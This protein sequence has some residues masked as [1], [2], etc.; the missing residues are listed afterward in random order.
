M[1]DRE[2]RGLYTFHLAGVDNDMLMGS[3][4]CAEGCGKLRTSAPADG[5]WCVRCNH[6]LCERCIRRH[7]EE[8][9]ER[10]TYTFV[11]DYH[12]AW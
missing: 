8:G 9:C 6:W 7:T 1:V 4:T 10:T 5:V 11:I 3:V 2:E 12:R